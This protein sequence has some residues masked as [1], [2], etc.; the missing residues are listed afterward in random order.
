DE[1]GSSDEEDDNEETRDKESFDPIL[2]TPESSE[3]EGDG[4]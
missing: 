2:Q 3:D 1:E 4:E